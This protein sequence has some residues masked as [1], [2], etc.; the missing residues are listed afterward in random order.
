MSMRKLW[1]FKLPN[2]QRRGHFLHDNISLLC[3]MILS[4]FDFSLIVIRSFLNSFFVLLH[5]FLMFQWL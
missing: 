4:P 3:H 1:I 5:D 2:D